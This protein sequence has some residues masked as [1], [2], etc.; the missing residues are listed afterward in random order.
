MMSPVVYSEEDNFELE[1]FLQWERQTQLKAS[2]H[3]LFSSPCQVCPG[4]WL[5]KYLC[6]LNLLD[7]SVERGDLSVGE[8]TLLELSLGMAT[9]TVPPE[10]KKQ[11]CGKGMVPSRCTYPNT[12]RMHSQGCKAKR[13]ALYQDIKGKYLQETL[14][15]YLFMPWNIFTLAVFMP[16]FVLEHLL[17]IKVTGKNFYRSSKGQAT[18]ASLESKSCIYDGWGLT[19]KR[20]QASGM[21]LMQYHVTSFSNGKRS[22]F[23]V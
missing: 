17:K 2:L 1:A 15:E 12:W 3:M 10:P 11:W 14:C 4:D 13:K 9:K 5:P 22:H 21:W 16:L 19:L 8:Q 18:I 23:R 6:H 7:M 20:A